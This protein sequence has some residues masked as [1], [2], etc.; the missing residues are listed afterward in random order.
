V[1][2]ETSQTTLAEF[3]A[4]AKEPL[5]PF[6]F[7]KPDPGTYQQKQF[8]VNYDHLKGRIL[9]W[10]RSRDHNL[11]HIVLTHRDLTKFQFTNHRK[12]DLTV[13]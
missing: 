11:L 8:E 4:S 9:T 2:Q 3:P 7:S 5:K 10:E 12:R 13:V 6:F 1:V